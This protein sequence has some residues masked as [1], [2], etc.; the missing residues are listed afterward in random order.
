MS[1]QSM[2]VQFRY[3]DDMGFGTEETRDQVK[4]IIQADTGSDIWASTRNIPPTHFL[5]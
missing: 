2:S 3:A 5:T 1:T 4:K